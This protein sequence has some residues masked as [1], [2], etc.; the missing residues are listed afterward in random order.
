MPEQP[1][2][3]PTQSRHPPEHEAATV[4]APGPIDADLAALLE[5]PEQPGEM[6]RLGPY[7]VLAVL[8]AG[9][10]GIVVRA[11][12]T[13]AGRQV[14]LKLIRPGLAASAEARQR[15]LREA[16]AV[17]RLDHDNIVPLY[18][19]GEAP[20]HGQPV[21]FLVMPL[22]RGESLVERLRREGRLPAGEVIRIGIEAAA[23]LQAAHEAGLVH[24]D[25]KP[26]NIWLEQR[27]DGPPRIR[28]LDFG[29]ARAKQGEVL[30]RTG[31][32]MGTPG[33][34]SPE[35][36]AG[37][38][39]DARSDL[40]SLGCV[41]YAM[42]T[43]KAPYPTHDLMA[44][45]AAL[46]A[47]TPLSPS[48]AACVPGPLSDLIMQLLSRDPAERPA[49]AAA[50]RQALAGIEV[51]PPAPIR[52][53]RWRRWL[54]AAAVV[55]AA[56]LP[57]LWVLFGRPSA[58]PGDASAPATITIPSD[59][60]L[61]ALSRDSIPADVLALAGDGDP[62]K[63]PA[64]IVA[65]L[66]NGQLRYWTKP[67]KFPDRLAIDVS[68]DGRYVALGDRHGKVRVW[69][70]ATGKFVQVLEGRDEVTA[71]ALTAE[72]EKLAVGTV[73]GEVTLWA[74]I[75]SPAV[76]ILRTTLKK[77]GGPISDVAFSPD[78]K[79]LVAAGDRIQLWGWEPLGRPVEYHPNK[80]LAQAGERI[81]FSPAGSTL[82]VWSPAGKNRGARLFN[83][84]EGFLP[85]LPVKGKQA[86]PSVL[87]LPDADP[88][89][90][91]PILSA[92]AWGD[93]KTLL[94]VATARRGAEIWNIANG[95]R[96]GWLDSANNPAAALSIDGKQA[97]LASA[98]AGIDFHA[99]GDKSRRAGGNSHTAPVVF[100]RYLDGGK[101]LLSAALDGSIRR[102]YTTDLV[103]NKRLI[104]LRTGTEQGFP[105]D[106][107]RSVDSAVFSPDG[108]WLYLAGCD[109][110]VQEYHLGENL[111][112][113]VPRIDP[114]NPGWSAGKRCTLA[115]DRAGRRLAW[116]N[117]AN[118]SIRGLD[119]V[120]PTQ[121]IPEVKGDI[122]AL[123]FADDGQSLAVAT[124]APNSAT[125]LDLATKKPGPH[126][127]LPKHPP[128]AIALRPGRDEA[129][130][131]FPDRDVTLYDLTTGQ[132]LRDLADSLPGI[133]ALAFSPDGR[134][135]AAGNA[136][137]RITVHDVETGERLASFDSAGV[138]ALAFR[139]D[140]GIL[141]VAGTDGR[142]HL[143]DARSGK[144]VR[145]LEVWPDGVIRAV[146]FSPAGRHLLTVNGNDTA[147]IYRLAPTKQ[148]GH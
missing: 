78:G 135:L 17:A 15:F 129:A 99:V 86:P 79:N 38:P 98:T 89:V 81:A 124:R 16:R 53:R 145:R 119:R 47:T 136:P 80:E 144:E 2:P 91:G 88:K 117:N 27:G 9:G 118:V 13:Q 132:R 3:Q 104:V 120:G 142:V 44:S 93:D 42:G 32:V 54:I 57:L 56:L 85:L 87:P 21:P 114:T 105:G 112:R 61:D 33:Y 82:A 116:G 62:A 49:S 75:G 125:V 131:A 70:I 7:R 140:G 1:P 141:A 31:T 76:P 28:L 39:L 23:G 29:L 37:K 55:V 24:R 96:L 111:P 110:V 92:V 77:E 63:A 95:K 103:V 60:A 20:A 65:I 90:P 83:V 26:A 50:V 58:R 71:V 35:Q 8:G 73:R 22:L 25:V 19:V 147:Y 68:A 5:P 11:E 107:P 146:L 10:M 84:S 74:P 100:V 123:G 43:G 66:G 115:I 45:L 130:V 6:G 122:I 101:L 52:R 67:V 48:D 36:A 113:L 143:L 139:P 138:Q 4:G 41:L 51:T 108:K 12:D 127:K 40:F 133:V 97:A 102:W 126:L 128:C 14:A 72:G 34:L 64:G 69:E 94:T 59:S 109:A 148:Q 121:R 137:G 18:H 46:A 106:V 30:T 134:R